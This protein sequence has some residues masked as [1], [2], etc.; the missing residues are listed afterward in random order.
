MERKNT[1][2]RPQEDPSFTPMAREVISRAIA[3]AGHW[4][5]TYVGTEHLL[6][7]C[8]DS[9][10]SAAGTALLKEGGTFEGI[11]DTVEK[12]IGRGTPCLPDENDFTPNAR[13]ALQGAV[14][15]ADSMKTRAG[16]E[17]I[18]AA[19]TRVRGCCALQIL[20]QLGISEKRLATLCIGTDPLTDRRSQRRRL[21]NLSRYGKELTD[22]AVCLNFDPLIGRE[23]EVQQVME[24]LCRRTKND[25]CLVGDA[26]VGK[27]AVVE[28]LAM[29]IMTG[30]VPQAL[31]G[32]RIFSLDLTLL[33]SGAKYR[34]DFEE[35]LKDCLEEAASEDGVILFIDELHNIMG[36][37]AAE[38]AIDAANILKPQLARG[39]LQL[40]GATTFEEYRRTIEKDAAMDRRFQRVTVREPDEKQTREILMGIRSRYEDYHGMTIPDEVIDG[41]VAL[42]GRY[43]HGRRFPDKAIDL[44]D[45]ACAGAKLTDANS[46]TLADKAFERYLLGQ[47]SRDDYLSVLSPRSRP[48]LTM[49]HLRGVI[50]RR[51]GISCP[52]QEGA[53]KFEGLEKRLMSS[54]IGQPGAVGAVCSAIKRSLTG[55]RDHR[56]PMGSFIFSGPTGVGKTLLAL[57]TAREFF[58]PDSMIKLD[59]SEYM[60][61][62]SVSK[63]IGAPP[64]YVGYEEGGELT[65]AVRRKPY[66]LVL[67]DEIE[68]A[69]P[70]IF[71]LLLQI[72]ED[73]VLTDR[74]GRKVS[75]ANTM[76]IMTTNAGSAREEGSR[77]CGFSAGSREQQR[78]AALREA[79][80]KLMP[81]ELLGRVD[82]T[83]FFSPLSLSALEDIAGQE[84]KSLKERTAA[85]GSRLTIDQSVLHLAAERAALTGSGREIRRIMTVEAE[86]LIC[87][88]LLKG[89]KDLRLTV[90]EGRFSAAAVQPA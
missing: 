75:F 88:L 28:G 65:E 3:L 5:H 11:K 15:L 27:T 26:G 6:A 13:S 4:G 19:M 49:E 17:H 54:V 14:C 38:G 21:K 16:S 55:L 60:E 36:T 63:L 1:G 20:S 52:D 51:T 46:R 78:E 48:E 43:I 42:S 74:T 90:C 41:A 10:D 68:K 29:R 45:E 62:H 33:L 37:G 7:A 70:D 2:R 44:M 76:I 18:L 73:G 83:V 56:R 84:A 69:H 31:S 71:Y 32:R 35:R 82:E 12:I 58:G 39:G 80:K 57:G 72:L 79:L 25:P 85:I 81:P 40:I 77:S 59:M 22:P 53:E 8:A 50:R 87:D 9:P 89:C 47:I 86:K 64:G 24:I 61:K 23:D 30:S 34:G 66:S 67:F